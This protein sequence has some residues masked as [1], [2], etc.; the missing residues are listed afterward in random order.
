[1]VEM[2][3]ERGSFDSFNEPMD[4]NQGSLPSNTSTMDQSFSW[5]KSMSNPMGNHLPSLVLAHASDWKSKSPATNNCSQGFNVWNCGE[6]SSGSMNVQDKGI[7]DDWNTRIGWPAM[8]FD[9]RPASNGRPENWSHEPSN[10]SSTSYSRSGMLLGTHNCS[11]N[12]GSPKASS[13]DRLVMAYNPYNSLESR[14]SHSICKPEETKPF[15]PL[16]TSSSNMGASAGG[17]VFP[18]AYGASGPSF[19]MWGLACK[20]EAHEGTTG[21]HYPGGGSSSSSQ[22]KEKNVMTHPVPDYY[23]GGQGSLNVPSSRLS[24]TPI[25][26]PQGPNFNGRMG[27]SRISPGQFSSSISGVSEN[28]GRNFYTRFDHRQNGPAPYDLSGNASTRNFGV[29]VAPMSPPAPNTDYSK[30]RL[31]QNNMNHQVFMRVDEARGVRS[32]PLDGSCGSRGDNS[33]SSFAV[34]RERGS[35]AH[36][37]QNVRISGRNDVEHFMDASASETRNFPPDEIDWSFA[38]ATFASSRNRLLGSRVGVSSGFRTSSAA[39]LPYQSLASQHDHQQLLESAP[40]ISVSNVESESPPAFPRSPYA[41]F[42][43]PSSFD[44]AASSNQ[45]FRQQMPSNS[46]AFLMPIPGDELNDWRG[47]TSV[48]GRNRLIR[49]VLNVVRRGGVR[50][51]SEG[52]QDALT[53]CLREP[54]CHT[55]SFARHLWLPVPCN[56]F[57]PKLL[58]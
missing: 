55:A 4:L 36:Q 5:E 26:H 45:P 18:E 28:S 39:W 35:G 6:S 11:S 46:A 13:N 29:F 16:N 7:A 56:M 21:Q 9:S 17:F 57:N 1:M 15:P 40:W 33:S 27:M 25:N 43:S 42:P 14:L 32:Y 10:M 38:P 58:L 30:M 48:D 54:F 44:R 24:V 12:F 23:N 8:P 51:P 37:E 3:Q 53:H 34:S 49:Q 22:L 50:I 2:Q 31:D 19:G 20:R 52:G 41:H 47:M